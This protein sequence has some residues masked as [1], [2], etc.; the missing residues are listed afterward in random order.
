MDCSTP[1]FADECGID[2]IIYRVREVNWIAVVHAW[3]MYE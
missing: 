2:H 1:G 3:L